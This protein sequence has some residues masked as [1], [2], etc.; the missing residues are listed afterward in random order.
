MSNR[1]DELLERLRHNCIHHRKYSNSQLEVVDRKKN[2]DFLST[3][4]RMVYEYTE[5]TGEDPYVRG[6]LRVD[7][8][9]GESEYRRYPIDKK[10]SDVIHMA[11]TGIACGIKVVIEPVISVSEW[12]KWEGGYIEAFVRMD[13]D[14]KTRSET[15]QSEWFFWGYLPVSY[16]G[17]LLES[18]D[19]KD[20]TVYYD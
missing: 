9:G 4:E 2:G 5:D 7:A 18:F 6:L 20:Y 8:L 12:E 14:K 1:A 17:E 3:F 19:L 15:G 10:L 16:L 13:T 11:H